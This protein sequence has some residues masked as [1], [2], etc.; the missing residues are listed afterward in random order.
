MASR[1]MIVRKHSLN[2]LQAFHRGRNQHSAR[3]L[4]K[5]GMIYE[6]TLRQSFYYEDLDEYDDRVYYGICKEKGD[7][8]I[9]V[10]PGF[11][12]K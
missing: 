6:G 12:H 1:Y 4:Q 3:V 9:P 7:R 8:Q 2:R 10:S 11:P 5:L